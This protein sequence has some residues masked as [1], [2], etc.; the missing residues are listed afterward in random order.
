M[1]IAM[2]TEDIGSIIEDRIMQM[3][4]IGNAAETLKA[5][6][7]VCDVNQRRALSNLLRGQERLDYMTDDDSF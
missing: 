2:K 3:G 1:L 7:E 5:M 4:V 6:I